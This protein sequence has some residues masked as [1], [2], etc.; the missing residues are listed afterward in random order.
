MLWLVFSTTLVCSV[1][2]IHFSCVLL[3]VV[4]NI[5]TSMRYFCPERHHCMT[6]YANGLSLSQR[7]SESYGCDK[8]K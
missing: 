5:I 8:F 7:T 1:N 3:F 6:I 4:T 2:S